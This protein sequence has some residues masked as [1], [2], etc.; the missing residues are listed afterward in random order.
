[1]SRDLMNYGELV[2]NALRSVVRSALLRV[3]RDGLPGVHHFYIIFRTDHPDVDI[4]DYLHAKYPD[5]MT[6][7]IQHQFGDLEVTDTYFA[8]TLTFSGRDERLVIPF[9]AVRKFADPAVPFLLEFEPVEDE[10]IIDLMESDE[11]EEEPK[12][13]P[14][15][16]VISLDQFRKK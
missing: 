15:G 11:D 10:D 1:M 7:V 14:A 9:A 5:E 3:V 16:K 2:E 4:P 12:E 13:K 6:V 8:V